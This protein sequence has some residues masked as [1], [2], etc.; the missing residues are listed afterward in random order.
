MGDEFRAVEMQNAQMVGSAIGEGEKHSVVLLTE[1]LSHVVEK[2]IEQA[3][4]WL[5]APVVSLKLIAGMATINEVAGS[6][7]A[8]M[9][10]RLQMVNRQFGACI[11]FADTAVSA[12][13][14]IPH[15]NR[16]P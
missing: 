16:L 11:D 5:G 3:E 6:I 8:A 2:R 10:L 9:M 1:M 7:I 4:V 14:V 15:L 13:V 12:T